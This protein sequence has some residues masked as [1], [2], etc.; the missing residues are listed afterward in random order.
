MHKP[1]RSRRYKSVSTDRQKDW[2]QYTPN[3]VGNPIVR[4]QWIIFPLFPFLLLPVRVPC[5]SKFCGVIQYLYKTNKHPPP[6]KKDRRLSC[7]TERT[8]NPEEDELCSRTTGTCRNER[9]RFLANNKYQLF[10]P[11]GLV[12]M[13][14]KGI[15]YWYL[16]SP[17]AKY[18]GTCLIMRIW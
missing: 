18:F 1:R 5:S 14:P 8:I 3:F 6:P 15:N 2:F 16:Y 13:M 11:Q 4:K 17:V 10:R 12:G 7:A 9:S